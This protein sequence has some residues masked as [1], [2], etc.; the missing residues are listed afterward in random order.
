M[1]QRTVIPMLSRERKSPR[2]SKVKSL[3][4]REFAVWT[5]SSIGDSAQVTETNEIDDYLKRPALSDYETTDNAY[6][7]HNVMNPTAL[8]V[9]ILMK[10]PTKILKN[11]VRMHVSSPMYQ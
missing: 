3:C 7:Q 6:T 5:H 11:K 1:A 2:V 9:K 10:N 4:T 8:Q